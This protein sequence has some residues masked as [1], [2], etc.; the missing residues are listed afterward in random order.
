MGNLKI[1][2]S[3]QI[4]FGGVCRYSL[5]TVICSFMSRIICKPYVE[6][7]IKQRQLL[8]KS[9]VIYYQLLSWKTLQFSSCLTLVLRFKMLF[10]K[11]F[12]ETFTFHSKS[13]KIHCAEFDF[14]SL[15]TEATGS[16]V[17][18]L[19]SRSQTRSWTTN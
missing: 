9:K 19:V 8:S 1:Y 6:S 11:D 15:C 10:N 16:A 7:K 18:A 12:L 3:T 14:I 13:L 2:H 17:S 5:K 4:C